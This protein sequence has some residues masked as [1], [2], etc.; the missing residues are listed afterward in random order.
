MS[1]KAKK[2]ADA[3]LL[4][5]SRLTR[6]LG[7]LDPGVRRRLLAY[8]TERYVGDWGEVEEERQPDG[9]LPGA[10]RHPGYGS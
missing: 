4:L 5:L 6:L 9:P 10:C 3:E 7:P 1:E 2:P 8:L